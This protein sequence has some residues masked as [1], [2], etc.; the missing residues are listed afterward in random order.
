MK[1]RDFV[2][3]NLVARW[4]G[5]VLELFRAEGDSIRLHRAHLKSVFVG[6]MGQAVLNVT[7]RTGETISQAVSAEA[8]AGALQTFVD[9]VTRDLSR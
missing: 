2:C 9:T 5:E 1:A 7:R 6:R 4:D 8:D 3:S